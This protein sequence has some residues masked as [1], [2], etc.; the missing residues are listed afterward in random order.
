MCECVAWFS[1]GA[2]STIACKLALQDNP[3]LEI[4]YIETGSHH[5]DNKRYLAD[6]EKWFGKKITVLQSRF[7]NVIEVLRYQRYINGP[8]GAPCTK[9]L[10]RLVREKYEWEHDIES[11]VWGFESG[12]KEEAR[13][14]RMCERYPDFKHIFP[15]IERG[16]N[17]ADCLAMVEK[18]GIELPAMYKLGYGNNNCVGCVKGGK[19]YWNKIRIDFPDR[20][21]EMARLEREIGAT[22]IKDT[23]LDELSPDAGKCDPVLPECSIFCGAINLG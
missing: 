16:L 1:C 12:R 11:Y 17:K 22:C 5:P 7:A 6:C 9:H 18:A 2:T 15:L 8:A 3:D 14:K 23:F 13:A 10:K 21:Q 20:F 19:G 4:V